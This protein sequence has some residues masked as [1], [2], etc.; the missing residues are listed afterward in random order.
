M[1]SP[2]LGDSPAQR[3][4][5][6][7]RLGAIPHLTVTENVPLNR[8]TR[9]ELGGPASLLVDAATEDA[10][11][12]ALQV[13][14]ES[15]ACWTLIGGGSNLVVDDAGFAGVVVRYTGSQIE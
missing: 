14:R 15:G 6:L 13:I 2:G 5:A 3:S 10:L 12:A 1:L 11:I 4:G 7:R 9:F 8:L